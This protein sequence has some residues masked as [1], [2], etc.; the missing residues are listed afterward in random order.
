MTYCQPLT[1]L[2][3]DLYSLVYYLNFKTPSGTYLPRVKNNNIN[4]L[5]IKRRKVITSEALAEVG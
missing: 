3:D 1:A 5:I 2:T 4:K